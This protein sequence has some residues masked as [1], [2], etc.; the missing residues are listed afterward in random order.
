MFV[1][2]EQKHANDDNTAAAHSTSSANRQNR[3][4]LFTAKNLIVRCNLPL[5]IVESAGFRVFMKDYCFKYEPISAKKLKRDILPSFMNNVSKTIHEALNKINYLSLT[6]DG[7]SDRRCRSFLGIT[8]HFIDD[9]MMSQAYLLDFVRHKSPHTGENIKQLTEDVLDRFEIK[10]KV[11]KIITDNAS[12]MI[13]AY[14]FGLF[15]DEE[16]DEHGDTSSSMSEVV[17]IFDDY[18]HDLEL[19]DFQAININ[20]DEDDDDLEGTT[21][22]R[23]SCFA[24]TLQLVV[25]DGFKKSSNI[26][27]VLN[28]CQVLAKFSHK[29]SKMADLLDEINKNINKMNVTRCNSEYLLIK[30]ILSIGKN[31]LDAITKLMDNSI[32]FSNNDLIVLEEIID[33]LEPFYEISVKCQAETIATASM[34]VPAVIHSLSHLHDIKENILFCTKLVQQLQ[35]SIET[36]FSGIIKRLNQTDIMENDPFSDP[37]YF[38]ATV[39]DPAF[40][41]YWIRDSGFKITKADQSFASL[42]SSLSLSQSSTPKPKKRKLFTYIN[43][44]ND[45]SNNS[46]SMDAANELQA[47]LSDPV[48]CRFSEYWSNT[49]LNIL[50]KLVQRI[51]SVQAS[52]APV[53]RVFSHAGLILS[54][55]Q[56]HM[57]EKLFKDILFLKINQ[58]L[59]QINL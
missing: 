42:S 19:S 56:T 37:V 59:L 39:L 27:R 18:D 53:K 28:K 4:L 50:H 38:M 29:S 31:D 35:L 12:S 25:R 24:H 51:F 26:S 34:V 20:H 23:L 44:N 52:S 32:Q 41:F 16:T 10:E 33:L 43:S 1:L 36:R 21:N 22:I 6:I 5:N 7:W 54:S 45:E 30:S 3:I 46:T 11:F 15:A 58:H 57:K 40:K 14:K 17:T 9:K 47:Y 8:C 48:R 55:R 49:R 13:K 2:S